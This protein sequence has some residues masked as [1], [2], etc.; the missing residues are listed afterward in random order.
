MSNVQR[1]FNK[2]SPG[3][4]AYMLLFKCT[5]AGIMNRYVNLS[6]SIYHSINTF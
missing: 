6:K 5:K 1:Y 2:H 4:L 3:M